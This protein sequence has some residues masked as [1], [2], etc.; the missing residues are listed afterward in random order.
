[1]VFG[2]GGLMKGNWLIGFSWNVIEV[3]IIEVRFVCWILGVVY[4]FCVE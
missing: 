1:M 2:W 3:R 4:L